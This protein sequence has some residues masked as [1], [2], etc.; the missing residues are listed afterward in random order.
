MPCSG[1][2]SCPV[3][4]SIACRGR[5]ERNFD[6]QAIISVSPYVYYD[7]DDA[8]E[9]GRTDVEKLTKLEYFL[10]EGKV[11]G[12][13]EGTIAK[14]TP[15]RIFITD[16][17]GYLLTLPLNKIPEIDPIEKAKR[18][19]EARQAALNQAA[20]AAGAAA[21]GDGGGDGGEAEG[22]SGVVKRLQEGEGKG[23]PAPPMR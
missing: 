22:N 14:I 5:S 2:T 19:A 9:T 17:N 15:D 18:E 11:L 20:A 16:A 7:G 3:L 1:A 6:S 21:A 8:L 10:T 4:W 23:A 12:N 13:N